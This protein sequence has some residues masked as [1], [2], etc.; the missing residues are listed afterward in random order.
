LRE[1]RRSVNIS[2]KPTKTGTGNFQNAIARKGVQSFRQNATT[3]QARS[4]CGSRA[5]LPATK[6]YGAREKYEMTNVFEPL[7]GKANTHTHTHTHT[8]LIRSKTLNFAM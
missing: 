5:T 3:A 4:I 7:P 6:H 1:P 8:T 2:G